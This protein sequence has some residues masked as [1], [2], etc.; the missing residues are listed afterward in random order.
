MPLILPAFDGDFLS[1]LPPNVF[2]TSLVK[3]QMD[4]RGFN[5]NSA[6]VKPWEINSKEHRSII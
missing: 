2:A 5:P 4:P 6:K 1:S 3:L